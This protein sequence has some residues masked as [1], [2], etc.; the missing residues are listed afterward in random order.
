MEQLVLDRK[1]IQP[2]GNVHGTDEQLEL[3]AL[4]R[5]PESEF[6]L[7]EE[8]L[9]VCAA[10]REKLDGIAD[11]ALGMR[12]APG[13]ERPQRRFAAQLGSFFRLPAFSMALAFST[14]LIVIAIFSNVRTQFAPTASLQLTAT[15]GEMSV[16]VP[17]RAFDLRLTDGPREGGPF[18]VEVLNAMGLSLWTGLAASSPV[19]VEVNVPQP[20]TQ[21][22]YFVRLYSPGGEML[23]EY[24]FRVRP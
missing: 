24:G 3:Y 19:G 22:D 12:E 9:I 6:A 20:L 11:F 17:A 16:T 14:L 1:G 5:L 13:T 10:C 23:R 7:I 4:N 8:H 21:G 18:K 15:R 2:G